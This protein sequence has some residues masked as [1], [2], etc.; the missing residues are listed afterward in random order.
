MPNLKERTPVEGWK[1]TNE[2][3]VFHKTFQK[4]NAIQRVIEKGVMAQQSKLQAMT[5]M[6][7]ELLGKK[8]ELLLRAPDQSTFEAADEGMINTSSGFGRK[9]TEPRQMNEVPQ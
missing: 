2:Q 3:K 6:L 1:L 8:K 5:G 4:V 7:K 9:P